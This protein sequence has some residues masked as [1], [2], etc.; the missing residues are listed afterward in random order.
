MGKV[1][2]TI[3]LVIVAAW[4]VGKFAPNDAAATGNTVVGKAGAAEQVAEQPHVKISARAFSNELQK[5]EVRAMAPLSGRVVEVTGIVQSVDLDFSDN[6]VVRLKGS[7]MFHN[8]GVRMLDKTA[9]AQLDK[10][11]KVTLI[12]D[13]GEEVIGDLM[14]EHGRVLN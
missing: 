12:G 1:A 13:K 3:G 2:K 5:N 4:A 11:Q 7:D 10:G 14:L 8:V 9:A 6:A